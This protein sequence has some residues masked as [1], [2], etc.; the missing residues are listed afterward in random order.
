MIN[1]CL[2][3]AWSQIAH[4]C[5]GRSHCARGAGQIGQHFGLDSR[6]Q[7]ISY[8]SSP[9]FGWVFRDLA[10]RGVDVTIQGG[11]SAFELPDAAAGIGMQSERPRSGGVGMWASGLLMLGCAAA[12]TAR[13]IHGSPLAGLIAPIVVGVVTTGLFLL[14]GH[15]RQ[16]FRRFPA[17][18]DQ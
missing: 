3:D 1:G 9:R 4:Q 5:L 8:E 17:P 7:I 16:I 6:S 12:I 10:R 13:L 11:L 18:E 15:S 2:V 14:A